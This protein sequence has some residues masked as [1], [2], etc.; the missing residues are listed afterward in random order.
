MMKNAF[1][2]TL[3]ALF[4]LTIF[5]VL[6]WLF[7]NVEKTALLESKVGFKIDDVTD[8]YCFENLM[9]AWLKTQI[10]QNALT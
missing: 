5:N 10:T 2:F 1:Y 9:T 6:S 7:V 4:V 8:I 3:N